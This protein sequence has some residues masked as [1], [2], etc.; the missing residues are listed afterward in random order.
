LQSAVSQVFNLPH[1]ACQQ[2]SA[3]YKSAIQQIKNLR[4]GKQIRK[5]A[6]RSARFPACGFWRL[7][8]RQMVVLSSCATFTL[9]GASRLVFV[10]GLD[11]PQGMAGRF[12]FIPILVLLLAGCGKSPENSPPAPV[13]TTRP[14]QGGKTD[15]A[16]GREQ[17]AAADGSEKSVSASASA[18]AAVARSGASDAELA[19]ALGELTQALRKYSFEHRRL[20][21]T[22]NEVV[23]A[24][25]V[26][27]MPQAPPGKKFEIDPKTVQVVLVKQ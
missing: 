22:F 5:T 27:D 12:I 16:P 7:S 18:A 3:D 21:K 8:S 4:Y 17:P 19:A 25:Y 1:A 11:L 2:R 26:K 6:L 20:P 15:G 9:G 13:S 24:G 10:N 23:A 14:A